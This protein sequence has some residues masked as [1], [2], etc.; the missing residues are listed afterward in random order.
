MVSLRTTP[1]RRIHRRR[2]P[3]RLVPSR[4]ERLEERLVLSSIVVWSTDDSGAGT[5]RQ[6]LLDAQNTDGAVITFKIQGQG[7]GPFRITPATPLP[8]ITHTLTID[9]TSQPGYGGTPL[10]E[11]DG[12]NAGSNADGLDVEASSCTIQGLAVDDFTGK[13]ISIDDSAA[14][15]N[16]GGNTVRACYLGVG[17]GGAVAKPNGGDGVFITDSSQNTVGGPSASDGNLISGNKGDGIHVLFGS[18]TSDANVF[19]NNRIGTDASGTV[20]LG[21]GGDGVDIFASSANDQILDNLISANSFDGVHLFG[22]SENDVTGAVVQG[23]LIGTDKDGVGPLGNGFA[24]VTVDGASGTQVLG[25]VISANG[26]VGVQVTFDTAVGTVI[27]G[28]LIGV[29]A[30]GVHALGNLGQ[31]VDVNF[32][33]TDVLV[34][35]TGPGDGNVIAYNGATFSQA[36]VTVESGSSGV[37]IEGNSIYANHGLGID[38]ADT[39]Q[40]YPALTSAGSS[41]NVTGISGTLNSAADTTYRVEFFASPG[42]D[43]TGYGQGK[44]YLGSRTVTTGDSGGGSGSASFDAVLAQGVTPGWV[45]S[46]TATDPQG[47]TSEFAQ[48]LTVVPTFGGPVLTITQSADSVRPGDSL[49]YTVDVTNL[50]NVAVNGVAVTDPVPAGLTVLSA[51]ATGAAGASVSVSGGVVTAGLASLGGGATLTLTI[52]TRAVSLGKYTNTVSGTSALGTAQPASVVTRVQLPTTARLTESSPT[53]VYGQP[54]TLTAAVTPALGS[55]TVTG[56]VTF[57]DGATP[58]GTATLVGGVATFSATTL[59]PGAHS[60]TAVSSGDD[61]YLGS[62]S[63]PVSEAVGVASTSAAVKPDANP[64]ALGRV[65]TLRATVSPV[66]PSVAA[67]SGTVTFFDNGTPIGT[68][69]LI[70]GIATLAAY[71]P[72]AG[73]HTLT[74]SYPG[75]GDFF[76]S[77]SPGQ[78]LTVTRANAQASLSPT[79]NPST[80]GQSITFTVT[81]AGVASAAG[82]TGTVQFTLDGVNLGAPVALVNGS[83]TSLAVATLGAGGHTVLAVYSGDSN[84]YATN[85][86]VIQ[87]V[88]K[89]HLTVTATNERKALGN[90][91]PALAWT[92]SGLVN[93]D[94]PGVVTGAPALSTTA[95][96][97]SPLGAY[98][99]TI[100]SRGTLAA[101]NYDFPTFVN[102]TLTVVPPTPLDFFGTGTADP[103]VFRVA[104]AQWFALGPNGGR[105]IA[106]YGA[107]NLTDLPVAA[108]YDGVGHA[109]PAVFRTSTDQW[110]VM[111]PNGGRLY[112]T[113]G[114]AGDVPV[115]AD[116]DGLGHA[117]P[118]VFRPSTGQWFVLGPTGVRLLGTWGAP[119][120]MDI[121]VPADYDGVGHAELAVFRVATAQWLVLGPAGGRVLATYGATNLMDIPVPGDYDGV[122]H[123]EPAV[124][125][126]STA[127]WFVKAPTGGHL[128]A[129]FGATNL[130]DIPVEGEG[131]VMKILGVGTATAAAQPLRSPTQPLIWLAPDEPTHRHDG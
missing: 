127:Q 85:G 30:D 79:A 4:V 126:Y 89:A 38:V 23:N 56:T 81:V 49:V 25:N 40:N 44:V 11:V 24:G 70:G 88:S 66:A 71:V 61:F 101:A 60:I 52:T 12:A 76:P 46:A 8:P 16:Y 108:D 67:P 84:Y 123:A 28:N 98:P 10:I 31:G 35:G 102:G 50:G 3:R 68:A 100:T 116:Y 54:L 2:R 18:G 105:M 99:I 110:F 91:N 57:M 111:G 106:T 118:G 93:G 75:D 1:D 72:P 9:G 26:G 109:E 107:T 120:L 53:S 22:G 37:T 36:G 63:N 45:V 95:T 90:P 27:Q 6:A 17:P 119:N 92:I 73:L 125:Q 41:G 104:T 47:N 83:A 74:A 131:A 29:A 62:T 114:Q 43:P 21:N 5:L 128:F 39:L 82:P 87:F 58:I 77:T 14:P 103:A 65:V 13:G 69:T 55:G 117:E 15:Q 97:T 94:N 96:T 19:R 33:A 64:S 115:P 86:S 130:T 59:A 48:D 78:A 80:Y 122:G 121:P 113:F 112:A 32:S 7:S 20:R 124:F 51:V 42:P 34:G 129:T